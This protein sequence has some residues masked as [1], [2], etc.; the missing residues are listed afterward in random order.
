M[1]HSPVWLILQ[2]GC[3]TLPPNRTDLPI[4]IA[5]PNCVH[6]SHGYGIHTP[7]P[8]VAAWEKISGDHGA[9]EWLGG[10]VVAG[11]GA[12]LPTNSDNTLRAC[13]AEPAPLIPRAQLKNRGHRPRRR[14]SETTVTDPPEAVRKTL[15][16]TPQTPMNHSP[17]Q[18]P[19]TASRLS[20]TPQT[21]MQH[22]PLQMPIQPCPCQT[23]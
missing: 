21:P 22:A 19:F 16:Q 15:S 3:T 7:A 12:L 13:C 11:A 8:A 2:A 9:E 17:L 4:C 5:L 6:P 18:E 23:G 20:Q 14:G 1:Q 10:A